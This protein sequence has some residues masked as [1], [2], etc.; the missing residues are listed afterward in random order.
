[1]IENR[2]LES[3][4]PQ[5]KYVNK[6][7]GNFQLLFDK[8]QIELNLN[9][10]QSDRQKEREYDILI[11]FDKVEFSKWSKKVLEANHPHHEK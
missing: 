7:G 5:M 4:E 10:D 8:Y 2:C 9:I 3:H 11:W 6:S 1:M